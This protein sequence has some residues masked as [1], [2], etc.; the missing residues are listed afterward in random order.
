[1]KDFDSL[2]PDLRK[3]ANRGDMEEVYRTECMEFVITRSYPL[4]F[5]P[6]MSPIRAVLYSSNLFHQQLPLF[7]VSLNSSS[8]LQFPQRTQECNHE[9]IGSAP[10]HCASTPAYLSFRIFQGSGSEKKIWLM[11]HVIYT[12]AGIS[13]LHNLVYCKCWQQ[14]HN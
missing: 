8:V 4:Y 9:P 3:I 6:S 13:V 12:S 2:E 10:I 11:I 1:M 7:S 14:I 5:W